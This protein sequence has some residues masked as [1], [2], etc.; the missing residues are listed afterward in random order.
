MAE[1]QITII[2]H[3]DLMRKFVALQGFARSAR[4]LQVLTDAAN[5]LVAMAQKDVPVGNGDARVPGMGYHLRSKI[6]GEVLDFGTDNP[7]I[8]FGTADSGYGRYVEEGTRP[9]EIRA[10]NKQW[11]RWTTNG[12]RGPKVPTPPG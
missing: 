9:H 8:R 12:P 1:V 7:K 4:M 5:T 6:F 2:G 3:E 10:R 11:L